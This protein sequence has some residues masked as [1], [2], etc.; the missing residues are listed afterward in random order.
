M[1]SS[2]Q[3]QEVWAGLRARTSGGLTKADLVKNK[4]GKL[5]SRKKSGQASSQNNLGAWLRDRGAKVS[6]GD[7]LRHKGKAEA[8]KRRT[9]KERPRS[10]A[11]GGGRTKARPKKARRRE[12][13]A[14]SP[15]TSSTSEKEAGTKGEPPHTA[16]GRTQI[17]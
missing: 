6:K 7:M 5:V 12:T 4:R 8:L 11:Q 3:R 14:Q 17:R 2:K 13:Q 10:E 16:A 9:E 1:P 15:E